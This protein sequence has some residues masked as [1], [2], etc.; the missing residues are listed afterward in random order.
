MAQ[1][2]LRE[3]FKLLR[4]W[5]MQQ[6]DEF[7]K[8]TQEDAAIFQRTA[9]SVDDSYV[10]QDDDD[11]TGDDPNRSQS[12]EELSSVELKEISNPSDS[13]FLQRM[14]SNSLQQALLLAMN[15]LGPKNESSN[16]VDSTNHSMGTKSL[17]YNG[18]D[19]DKSKNEENN[20]DDNH[21]DAV[22]DDNFNDENEGD[23]GAN[24]FQDNLE[25][26]FLKTAIFKPK[27]EQSFCQDLLS[28]DIE[29]GQEDE[30]N[31]IDGFYP[32]CYSEDN[33][34]E[35]SA[36][37]DVLI[38]ESQEDLEY[39]HQNIVSCVKLNFLNIGLTG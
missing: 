31:E 17:G 34:S 39:P 38:D 9:K 32:I 33:F 22:V 14:T 4:Q 26:S 23:I 35:K 1:S 37:V 24:Y 7:R 30:Q 19:N 36:E 11:I 27:I 2:S 21:V 5:Q 13:R 29:S 18:C 10:Q 28:S 25:T 8:K 20:E 15:H 3:K 12:Y 6:Q 16:D